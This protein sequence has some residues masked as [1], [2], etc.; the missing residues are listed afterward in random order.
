MK[1][2]SFIQSRIVRAWRACIEEDYS[3]QRVNSERSLQASFWS[4]INP[5]LP[6][7]RRL[8]IEPTLR[9]WTHLVTDV[10]NALEVARA[11]EAMPA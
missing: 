2:R 11:L 4:H 1:Q 8:F 7:T 3:R 5:Q 9:I 10:R 6:Q